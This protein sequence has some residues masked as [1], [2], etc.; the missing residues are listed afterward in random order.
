[1]PGYAAAGKPAATTGAII[2]P[3]PHAADDEDVY[4]DAPP[5]RRRMGVMAIA[6]VF[7]LAV[8]GTAGAFGYRA[9]FG[10]SG[11]AAP[12]PVIKADTAP[13]KIVPA[14]ASKDASNKLITDR[15][16]RSRSRAK[17]WCR[18][19]SSRSTMKDKPVAVVPPA[20][21]QRAAVGRRRRRRY[22]S[23]VIATEPKKIHTIAIRPDQMG[24]ADAP[25]DAAP[26]A[27]A[28]APVAPP[29]ADGRAALRV[30]QAAPPPRVASNPP[31]VADP[32]ARRRGASQARAA[33]PVH[34]AAPPPPKQCAAVAEPR[35]DCAACR[36]RPDAHCGDRRADADCARRQH[37]PARPAAMPCRYPRSAARPRRR[38][39]STAC[40][41]SIPSQLGGRAADDPR[42]ELG[43]KGTY[44]RAMVGPF[45]STAEA[46]TL[47]SSLKAA[48]G[49]CIVQRN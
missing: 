12:P 5:P 13:S 29:A 8:I 47:C 41:P 33:A 16:G 46:S 43:A 10:S 2:R 42:V 6:A 1:M 45:A 30:V 49:Q 7:A 24:A 31:A 40:R 39:R 22:G 44:Y 19:K 15:V 26:P 14:A 17:N 32:P 11:A 27:A 21:G 35:R 9:L 20:A 48:G 4:D 36:A 34:R 25:L 28:P 37:E 18:A 3:A 23:G 38:P